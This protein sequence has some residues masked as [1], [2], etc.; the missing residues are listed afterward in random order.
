MERLPGWFANVAPHVDGV[1]ALDDGSTDGS[2][3]WLARRPQVRELVQIAPDRPDWDEVGNFRRLVA[4]AVRHGG[5]WAV[6]LDAD[7]RVERHFRA[8]AERVIR[9]GAR[10]G[11]TG[12]AVRIREVWN[13]PGRY[14]SDGLWSRKLPPR[15]FKLRADHAFDER[16]LHAG[17][18]PLQARRVFGQ[19]P[20]ADLEVYHL[21]MLRAADRRA[22]RERYERADPHAIWQPGQ[23]YA[24][25]TDECGLAVRSI[26]PDRMWYED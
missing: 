8:R 4:A 12:Y 26:P 5:D 25:L 13:E 19:V 1:V 14:R 16:P 24:Y 20:L 3:E 6:V 15:L 2:A 23:G 18:V 9:R 22:R 11:L 21:G 10:L 17:K 7:E